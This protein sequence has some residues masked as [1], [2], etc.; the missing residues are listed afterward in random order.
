MIQLMQVSK[1]FHPG[2]VNEVSALR[3]TDL[4]VREGDFITIIGSNGAGKSTL[5]NLVA[6]AYPP[7]S[8]MIRIT[9]R[10]VTREPEYRRAAYIGRIFQNPMLGTAGSMTLEDNMMICYRRV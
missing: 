1:T 5:F 9:D 7:S 10:D 4:E 2:T 6:G 3:P 8:G